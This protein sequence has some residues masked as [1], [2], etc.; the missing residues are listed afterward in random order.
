MNEPTIRDGF[1]ELGIF[2]K[3]SN[4]WTTS[5]DLARVFGK[6]HSKVMRS[7]EQVIAEA[8]KDWTDA[9]FG[10]SSYKDQSGKKNKQY[11]MTRKGF[12]LVA[13][14]F[15]GKKAMQFK[16]DYIEAFENMAELIYSRIHAKPGYK[17]MS[18]VVAKYLGS[19]KFTFAEEANRVNRAVLG[20]TSSEFR[21][22]HGLKKNENPRDAVIKKKLDQ[23]DSAQRLNANLIRAGVEAH[24]RTRILEANYKGRF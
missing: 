15:T 13:M 20:M 23:I 3:H 6:D 12:S 14:G 10:L 18:G 21:E 11:R 7:I 16:V 24:E 17:E 22:V 9:N 1:T 19:N 2:E 4:A 5:R 8:D